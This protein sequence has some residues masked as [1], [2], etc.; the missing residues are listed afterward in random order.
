[1]QR[2]I[3]TAT[4]LT[5]LMVISACENERSHSEVELV[6]DTALIQNIDVSLLND[7]ALVTPPQRVE[8]ILENG[9]AASCMKLVV[10]YLPD[11]MQIGPFCPE[12][13]NDVGGIWDWDGEDPGLYRVDESFLRKLDGQGYTFFDP[14]GS[15]HIADIAVAEPV[16]DHACINVSEDEDV[17]ITLLVPEHSVLADQPTQLRVVSKVGIALDGVPIFSDA[18]SVARTGHMP[19]L[20]T[21]GG[22]VDPGGWYHFHGTASDLDTAFDVADVDANCRLQQNPAA[23]FGF[24]YDGF[25]IYGSLELDGA[26]PENL[27]ECGGHDP[28]TN[29]QS[30]HYHS[31]T[32]FPN[33][34]KCLAG[35]VAED[36]FI[37]TAQVGVGAMP[38]QG[39]EITRGSPPGGRGDRPT[40]AGGMPPGFV[41]AAAKLGVTPEALFE[42]MEAAGGA[43]ADLA[44][45]AQAL[46]VSEEAL[47]AAL[48]ARP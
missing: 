31:G 23:L 37:T 39:T 43:D 45:V 17:E 2:Y 28:D 36:N 8:C 47:R 4:A 33:L 10:K 13:L 38:A 18:P 44:E 20:D 16:H 40:G 32:T 42:A 27:D 11:D 24:A 26:V 19:A 9:E 5:T 34:P 12:T 29:G 15:V 46:G 14:D 6:T 1:M 48:P 22:H 30:Y 7:K 35:V 3:L 25:P 21:C 41:E